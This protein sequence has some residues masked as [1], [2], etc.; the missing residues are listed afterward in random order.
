MTDQQL[1][2]EFPWFGSKATME[3]LEPYR[4]ELIE[5][6]YPKIKNLTKE[7]IVK[8]L[9]TPE[10]TGPNGTYFQPWMVTRI[11]PNRY[12]KNLWN[13]EVILRGTIWDW[14]G[15]RTTTDVVE[16][17]SWDEESMYQKLLLG[18]L[19]HLRWMY[20]EWNSQDSIDTYNSL[21]EEI[22]K[23]SDN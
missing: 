16:A 7:Q 14:Y 11:T 8:M 3:G 10:H 9:P 18:Y 22:T 4:R 5:E 2:Y 21:L 13:H 19:S 15:D 1:R 23:L 17:M 6:V 20:L 12:Y